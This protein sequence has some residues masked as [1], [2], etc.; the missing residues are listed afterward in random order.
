MRGGYELFYNLQTMAVMKA[1]RG[2]TVWLMH[3]E[4]SKMG[5][6]WYKILAWAST[7]PTV[8]I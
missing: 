2:A 8:E 7:D 3:H 6:Y 4:L 1:L 5:N